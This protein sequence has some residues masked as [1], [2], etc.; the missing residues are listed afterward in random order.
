MGAVSGISLIVRTGQT[1][2]AGTDDAVYLGIVG[3]GQGREFNLDV[4]GVDDYE[5]GSAIYTIGDTLDAGAGRRPK[6]LHAGALE[7]FRIDFDGVT[8][9]YL[10]KWTSASALRDDAWQLSFA[11]C[12]IYDVRP[13]D[14]SPP[15]F[16][17][18]ELNG[19]VWLSTKHGAQVW[20]A[21]RASE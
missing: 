6:S 15:R 8:H 5:P 14:G 7:E 13:A 9:V 1:R 19:P 21:R 12:Y 4:A 11:S 10:R 18:F 20:F 2:T 17:R 16:Q 3:T